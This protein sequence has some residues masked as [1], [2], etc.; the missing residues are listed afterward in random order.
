M[1]KKKKPNPKENTKK[2]PQNYIK[3]VFNNSNKELNHGSD[4]NVSL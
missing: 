1:A 4:S 3:N 2:S